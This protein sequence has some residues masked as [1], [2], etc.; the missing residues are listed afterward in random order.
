MQKQVYDAYL[1]DMRGV[2]YRYALD[3]DQIN[4]MVQE[5][6]VNIFTNIRKFKWLG[7]GSFEAWM[8]KVMANAAIK[9]YQRNK[10]H[11]SKISYYNPGTEAS[12]NLINAEDETNPMDDFYDS[13]RFTNDEIMQVLQS[14]PE[15]FRMV[16]NLV[17]IEGYS[18]REVGQILNI[19]EETSRT[20]LSRAKRILK[21][22]LL[23]L[24][25]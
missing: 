20:R 24:E 18:H 1:Y 25:V 23:S 10:K 7:P 9:Y 5:G 22:K 14:I 2:C 13:E 16:F 3:N 21:D 8:R 11:T 19:K 6:F 15:D 12:E 17:V 4:D